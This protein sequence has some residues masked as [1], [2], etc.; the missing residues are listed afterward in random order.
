MSGIKYNLESRNLLRNYGYLGCQVVRIRLNLIRKKNLK[1]K[2][3]RFKLRFEDQ[4]NQPRRKKLLKN[5]LLTVY[6]IYRLN[7]KVKNKKSQSD[8]MYLKN[9]IKLINLMSL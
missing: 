9:S 6:R 4:H 7:F 2:V 3:K 8:L 1:S 5:L